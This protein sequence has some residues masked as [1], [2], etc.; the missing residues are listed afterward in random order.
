VILVSTDAKALQL[1]ASLSTPPQ[2]AAALA[3]PGLTM[4]QQVQRYEAVLK[5]PPNVRNKVLAVLVGSNDEDLASQAASSLIR[6]RVW[7]ISA[8]INANLTRW[9]DENVCDVLLD[10]TDA[11]QVPG[12]DP[13]YFGIARQVLRRAVQA[14][15]PLQATDANSADAAAMILAGGTAPEDI[16]LLQQAAESLPDAP[17]AWTS[18]LSRNGLNPKLRLMAQGLVRRPNKNLYY[19]LAVAA[20]VAPSDG[21]ATKFLIAQMEEVLDKYGRE[22]DAQAPSASIKIDPASKMQVFNDFH[23][24]VCRLDILRFVKGPQFE[25]LTFRAVAAARAE[26]IQIGCLDAAVNYPAHL[27]EVLASVKMPKQTLVNLL[28]FLEVLHP[29]LK[30]RISVAS[31]SALHTTPRDIAAAIHGFYSNG[32]SSGLYTEGCYF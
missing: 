23:T 20:A 8:S 24:A 28:A 29:E 11:V 18:L 21:Y 14:G 4:E 19:R 5:L 22:T 9:S 27:L 26:V 32:L 12:F 31:A 30:A 15:P 6:L 3:E 13:S 2:I 1:D 25:N 16:P 10:L 17:S 7:G